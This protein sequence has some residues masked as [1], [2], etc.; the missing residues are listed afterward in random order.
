MLQGA[1]STRSCSGEIAKY[2]WHRWLLTAP[3]YGAVTETKALLQS[4]VAFDLEEQRRAEREAQ[5]RR[6]RELAALIE[7]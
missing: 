1:Q 4:A 2:R 7:D 6:F 5:V 3:L